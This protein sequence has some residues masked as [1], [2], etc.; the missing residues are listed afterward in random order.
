MTLLAGIGC[1]ARV[2]PLKIV[3]GILMLVTWPIVW[4]FDFGSTL[5]MYGSF[6]SDTLILIYFLCL[7]GFIFT[8]IAVLTFPIRKPT[9]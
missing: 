6:R 3:G 4:I 9:N 1:L 2:K 8:C 7:I 5:E